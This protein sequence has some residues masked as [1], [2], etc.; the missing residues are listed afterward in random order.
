MPRLHYI[1]GSPFA[2][3]LRVLIREHGLAVEES[4]VEVFPPPPDFFALNPLGQVPVYESGG[5]AWFP[6][7]PAL[8]ALHA[9]IA[10]GSAA[11]PGIARTLYRPD[12]WLHDL[13]TLQ[14][15]MALGDL[16]VTARYVDWTGLVQ[17]NPTRVG[18][19]IAERTVTRA[20]HALDWLER[21][22]EGPGFRDDG[23]AAQDIALAA[24]LLW[25]DARD[26]IGWDGRPGVVA[27]VERLTQRASFVDTAPPP[28][29]G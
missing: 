11:G 20:A 18:F 6:T 23:I 28:W 7:L 26:G 10:R 19:T 14:V 9:D 4:A 24:I 17:S 15:I 27:L 22:L 2:R 3:I 29:Q 8:E 21:R 12:R 5:T 13:Q 25:N 16:T 1:P